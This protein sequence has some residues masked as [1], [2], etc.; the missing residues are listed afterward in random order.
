M[1]K[2]VAVLVLA[3]VVAIVAPGCSKSADQGSEASATTAPTAPATPARA[4]NVNPVTFSGGH[5]SWPERNSPS[6]SRTAMKT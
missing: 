3:L 4:E 1:K 2:G 5:F 6:G